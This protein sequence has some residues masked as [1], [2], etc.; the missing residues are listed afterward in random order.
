MEERDKVA[1]DRMFAADPTCAHCTKKI[2]RAEDAGV[3]TSYDEKKRPILTLNHISPTNCVLA[4]ILNRTPKKGEG[5][6]V[7]DYLRSVS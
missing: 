5:L 2:D 1:R 3:L 7:R 6:S 4:A